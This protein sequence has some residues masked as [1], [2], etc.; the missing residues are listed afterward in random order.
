MFKKIPPGDSGTSGDMFYKDALSTSDNTGGVKE[1][2][3][4]SAEKGDDELALLTA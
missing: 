1:H 3:N 2:N 4:W